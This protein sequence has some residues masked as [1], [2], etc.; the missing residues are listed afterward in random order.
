MSAILMYVGWPPLPTA[1][2]LLIGLAPLFILRE[3]FEN[4]KRKHLK[5]WLWVYLSM[6]LFNAGTTWWVWNASPEG[7]IA[8]LISNSLLMSLPY[9]VYS[10]LRESAPKLAFVGFVFTYIAFEYWHFNWSAA[11]PWLTLGKGFASFPMYIQWYEYTG[12][13]GGSALILIS[14]ILVAKAFI[15]G[16]LIRLWKPLALALFMGLI[17]FLTKLN[18]F[19]LPNKGA[20]TAVISQPN[21]D[22]YT[23][24]F[25]HSQ[26][27]YLYPEIQLDYAIEPCEKYLSGDVDLLVLPETA[28]TG[29][30][31]ES[32]FDQS[33]LL[34]PLKELSKDTNLNIVAGAETFS[35]YKSLE[36]PTPTARYDSFDHR[37]FDFYNT[38]IIIKKGH[39]GEIYHKSKL[40]PGVEKMPFPFLEKLILNLGGASGSLGVSDRPIN[41]TMTNGIKVAPLICYESVFGDYAT[42]YVKNGANVLAVITN[43]GWWGET[44]G[45]KQHLMYGAIR[46]I[47]NRREMLRSANTGVSAFINKYGHISMKTK[48]KERTAFKCNFHSFNELT[49]YVRYGN[50]IGKISVVGFALTI[51]TFIVSKFRKKEKA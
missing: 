4:V 51:L 12:E 23:E 39:L 14:N 2:L 45:Y 10:H 25:D 19:E 43:D 28:I 5:Y 13:L 22:P 38:G 30:N 26:L 41:F 24:K 11:W 32:G 9:L 7:S 49:F 48:Y 16:K 31:D 29:N 40:V 21:I 34:A 20:Y 17:S 1:L 15:Q 46:C 35:V 37:W 50:L 44:P 47:E 27:N 36:R 42:E 18:Y 8:M 33:F 3:K 6:F